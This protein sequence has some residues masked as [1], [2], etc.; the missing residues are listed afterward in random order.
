MLVLSRKHNNK[1][2]ASSVSPYYRHIGALSQH[3]NNR[4]AKM[5]TST[6]ISLVA[7]RVSML[8]IAKQR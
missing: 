7:E 5:L 2:H 1:S 4:S 6:K 8:G 3:A